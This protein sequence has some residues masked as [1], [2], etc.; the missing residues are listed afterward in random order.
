MGTGP[1]LGWKESEGGGW[2]ERAQGKEKRLR[3]LGEGGL[4][5][6]QG[7][8]GVRARGGTSGLRKSPTKSWTGAMISWGIEMGVRK[9]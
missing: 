2:V 7:D 4:R 6:S 3:G 1:V 5:R 8:V 9:P